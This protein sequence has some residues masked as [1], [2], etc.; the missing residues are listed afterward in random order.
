MDRA[1]PRTGSEDIELYLRTYYSLLRSTTEVQIRTLE[2]VHA[3]MASSLHPDVRSPNPDMSALIYCSL[4]LPSCVANVDRVILG[5]SA[6][7][8]RRRG[9]GNVEAWQPVAAKAR[10]RRS[11]YDGEGTLACYIASRSDIDDI[12]PMLTAFQIEWNKLH[13]RMQGGQIRSF[14]QEPPEDGESLAALAGD[15]G[16][17]AADIERLWQVWG[18]DFWPTMRAIAERTKRIRVW[19][20]SGSLTDY[21][22]ATQQWWRVI[23]D[24]IPFIVDRPVYFVSSN[25]HSLVNL[26]TGFAL[27]HEDELVRLLQQPEHNELLTEWKEIEAR[28]LPSSRE[29]FL[30]YTLKKYLSVPE[31][32]QMRADRA[33][34][35]AECGIRR[36]P[37]QHGFDVE[38]QVIELS[39]LRPDWLDPRLRREGLDAVAG[40]EALIVNIDYPLGMAAY[41]ILSHVATRVGEVRGVYVMGKAATLNG[42]VG[43]VMV[44]SVVYDEH[45]MNTYLF[46]NCFAAANVGEGMVYGT[47]LDNQ[48]AVT[49]RGTFLQNV[50]YIDVFYREGYTD[51]EMEA[52]PYLSA[53]YEMYRPKRH[54]DNEIVNLYGLP[55]ELGILHYA[56]DTPLSKGRNLAVGSLSYFGMEPTYAASLAILKRVL[57]L[58]IIR[59]GRESVSRRSTPG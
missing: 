31:G 13:R 7:V 33:A 24:D 32:R 28:Q 8:F 1:V 26:F 35:E 50:Q 38:V 49:V 22:R 10:R 30:Y 54:P 21:E 48:K 52:G 36:Y 43:D 44:P 46:E 42:V 15:V 12:L 18:D 37:S 53:V 56:S 14:L 58:E 34:A 11:F 17:E 6:E 59:G 57:D 29:N 55:F 47:V 2:E 4:R 20:L 27:R 25:T 45:S 39:R 19:L 40:S 9:A 51:I 3:N 41:Q 5:Q 16:V 23:E